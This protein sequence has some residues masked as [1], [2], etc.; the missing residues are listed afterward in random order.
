M[1]VSAS[2]TSPSAQTQPPWVQ[3]A[4][5]DGMQTLHL[6][7]DALQQSLSTVQG[8]VKEHSQQITRLTTAHKDKAILHEHTLS[9]LMSL[10]TEVQKLKAQ[11]RSVSP[12]PPAAGEKPWP[13][14]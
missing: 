13:W 11:S 8:V 5:L 3:Q 1:P 9:R 6:K 14:P 12:A 4:L 10:E 2:V 7:Q